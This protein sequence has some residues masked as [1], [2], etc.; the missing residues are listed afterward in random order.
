MLL[1]IMDEFNF[2]AAIFLV[3]NAQLSEFNISFVFY[4]IYCLRRIIN[5]YSYQNYF[6]KYLIGMDA[7]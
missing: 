4:V 7:T 1:P 5:L 3:S 6:L 2:N